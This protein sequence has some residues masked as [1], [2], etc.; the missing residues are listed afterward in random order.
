MSKPNKLGL[1]FFPAYDW[2][3]SPTHPERVERLLYTQDQLFEE[4]ILDIEGLIMINPIVASAQDIQRV[5]VC[6][7]DVATV[8]SKPHQIAAGGAIVAGDALLSKQ[9]DK[10][11]ALVRPPGHHAQKVVYG[12]RGFCVINNEAV[13]IEYLRRKYGPLKVAIVDTDAHHGD[14]TENIY[15]NDKDTLVISMHQDG[16]TLYP[17]S[18]FL[19]ECGGPSAYGYNINI[20]LPPNTAE[21]GF[22]HVLE[23][24]IMP[25]LDDFKPDL[26]VNSAG[27]DNHYSD[28][29][30]NM[31]FTAGGY[32]KLNDIL[33]SNVAV[34]EGGYSIEGALP[35]INLGIILAMA[36]LDYS[37]VK[38]PDYDQQVKPQDPQISEYI[39]MLSKEVLHLWN[40][41]EQQQAQFVQ[42]KKIIEEHRHV[43]YDTDHISEEQ[44]HF[45]KVC[46]DCY[47]HEWIDS[48][49]DQG[50]HTLIITLPRNACKEC[51]QEAYDQYENTYNG[52]THVYLQ[53]KKNDAFFLKEL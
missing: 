30:T 24:V 39:N 6:V 42:D 4:G 10:A 45:F 8:V 47:G 19:N 3:I 16:R 51:V 40:T 27:Q 44:H 29:I 46:E 5:H 32:A 18:G 53:D 20:P 11:F 15:W 52:F 34:L 2:Q 22:L 49:S 48:S 38:E 35:Y 36:G 33:Q 17:G 28:P 31:R 41:K 50:Y 25:I 26:I 7:P 37:L 21:E 12:N 23:N 9:V 43:Y 1:V 14:G 13:M